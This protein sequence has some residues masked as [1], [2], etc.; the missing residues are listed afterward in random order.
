MTDCPAGLVNCSCW[1]DKF[2]HEK[3][4]PQYPLGCFVYTDEYVGCVNRMRKVNN[5]YVYRIRW[6]K[7]DGKR[8]LKEYTMEM[9][10]KMDVNKTLN[11]FLMPRINW[12][13]LYNMWKKSCNSNNPTKKNKV[14]EESSQRKKRKYEIETEVSELV[15]V[16]N[17]PVPEFK[18]STDKNEYPF[19]FLDGLT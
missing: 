2:I 10:E 5:F 9:L 3:K 16:K 17:V 11:M 13:R 14:V 1:T 8:Y 15:S 7:K 18:V 19:R 4:L 6:I 12:R